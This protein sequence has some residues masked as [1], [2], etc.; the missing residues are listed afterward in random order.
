MAVGDQQ[1]FVTRIRAVLPNGWFSDDAPVLTALLNGIAYCLAVMYSLI[2][3]T[4]AQTRIATASDGFLD[5]VAFDYFGL[6]LQRRVSELDAALRARIFQNLLREKATRNGVIEALTILTGQTPI[7]FEPWRPLDCGA[8]NENICGLNVAGG[9]G[10]LAVPYQGFIIAYRPLGQGIPYLSGYNDP[11]G[12]LNTPSYLAWANLNQVAGGVTDA[13]M[14]ATVADAKV[15]GTIAWMQ[16]TDKTA[17]SSGNRLMLEDR[18][19][20]IL[21]ETGGTLT[22]EP[23]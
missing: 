6:A 12:A 5:L 2:A 23:P 21:L 1:D 20:G 22:L 15:E 18:S 7:V 3:Y 9:W 4:K 10:S 16:I 11:Q 19:G 17:P 14:F 13:D 8:W